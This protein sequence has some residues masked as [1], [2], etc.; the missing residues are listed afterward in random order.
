M[1]KIHT[2]GKLSRREWRHNG[3]LHRI[4]GPAVILAHGTEKW[5]RN[6]QLHRI[7]GPA[8]TQPNGYV[9]YWLNGFQYDN[10]V[11]Y[12]MILKT[13]HSTQAMI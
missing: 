9:E 12:E 6:G 5:Y 3:R 7:G 13:T 2:N 10:H 11:Q 4:D 8:V 1:T